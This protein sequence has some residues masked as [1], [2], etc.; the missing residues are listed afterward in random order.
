[1]AKWIKQKPQAYKISKQK[2]FSLFMKIYVLSV[3]SLK[4]IVYKL[5][6]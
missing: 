1:M 5:L 2:P 6:V 3:L 4:Y